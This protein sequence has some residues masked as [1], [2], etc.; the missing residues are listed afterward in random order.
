MCWLVLRSG[1]LFFGKDSGYQWYHVEMHYADLTDRFWWVFMCSR[2]M[3]Q[4]VE[5]VWT[6]CFGLHS[7]FGSNWVEL[8]TCFIFCYTFLKPTWWWPKLV[9]WVYETCLFDHFGDWWLCVNHVW[10]FVHIF[11]YAWWRFELWYDAKY[12]NKEVLQSWVRYSMLCLAA[13]IPGICKF[14]FIVH[15]HVCYLCNTFLRRCSFRVVAL[16][17]NFE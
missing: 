5:S 9:M 17:V 12:Q 1:R 16:I 7:C 6:F 11:T 2:S 3:S 4:H 10:E 15:F 14:Y 8:C 13:T